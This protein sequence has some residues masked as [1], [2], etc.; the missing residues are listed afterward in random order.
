MNINIDDLL[1]KKFIDHAF[2]I[3]EIIKI[4]KTS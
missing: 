4:L 1:F 3:D 2:N